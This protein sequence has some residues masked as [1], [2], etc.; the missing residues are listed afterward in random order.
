MTPPTLKPA[1]A[2][3]MLVICTAIVPEFV[4]VILCEALLPTDT[5]ENVRLVGLAVNCPTG[6]VDPVPLSVMVAVGV[7]G[8]LLVK[9]MLPEAGPDAAGVNVTVTGTV[10]PAIIVFGVAMPVI[11]K[12][13]P[14]RV[15]MEMVKSPVPVLLIAKFA[16]PLEAT[17]TVPKS[18]EAG[19]TD[20]CGCAAVIVPERLTTPGVEPESPFMVSVPLKLPEVVPFIQTEKPVL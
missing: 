10:C 13:A 1:P 15:I 6:A 16:V 2:A 3:A 11:A 5:L 4:K 19:F 9:V 17:V 8:S 12:S 20:N 7:F 14:L 18:R